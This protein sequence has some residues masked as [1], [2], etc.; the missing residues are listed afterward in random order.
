MKLRRNHVAR[1]TTNA[2]IVLVR[3]AVCGG[4]NHDNHIQLTSGAASSRA[5]GEVLNG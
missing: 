3:L 4:N 5:G 1:Q 2:F